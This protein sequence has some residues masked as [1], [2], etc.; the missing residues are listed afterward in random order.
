MCR[1]VTCLV[2]NAQNKAD[3]KKVCNLSRFQELVQSKQA[4]VVWVTENWL[5]SFV[6]NKEILRSGYV[7]S[8]RDWGSCAGGVLLAVK[9]LLD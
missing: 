6:E 3:G 2:I 9:Y 8:Q 5:T 7:I 1:S 4:D